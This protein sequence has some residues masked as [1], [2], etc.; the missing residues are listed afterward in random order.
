M[1]GTV[2][3]DIDDTIWDLN[4]CVLSEMKRIFK[5]EKQREDNTD[6]HDWKRWCGD[7]W[8]EIFKRPLHPDSVRDRE[9]FPGCAAALSWMYAKGFAIHFVSHNPEPRPLIPAIEDWLDDK[10]GFRDYD[11]TIVPAE[12]DKIVI[13]DSLRKPWGIIEDKPATLA[14][15]AA[16][17]YHTFCYD[18]P[19]NR[20]VQ[21]VYPEIVVFESW[22]DLPMLIDSVLEFGKLERVAGGV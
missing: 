10:L 14:K 7:D 15:A 12:N 18:R 11:L 17:G 13:L 21:E 6:W 16:C 8:W 20:K 4:S 19:V 3:V 1:I 5:V 9:L 2:V 22:E